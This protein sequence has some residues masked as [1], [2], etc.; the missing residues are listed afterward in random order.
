MLQGPFQ[1]DSETLQTRQHLAEYAKNHLTEATIELEQLR[2][3]LAGLET[4]LGTVTDLNGE[5]SLL[6]DELN[7]NNSGRDR[8]RKD[9]EAAAQNLNENQMKNEKFHK[10]LQD[11]NRN[12]N[13]MLREKE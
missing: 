3:N 11:E 12:L 2:G 5:L 7:V 4:K 8:L 13:G 6:R 9:L 10:L 1:V